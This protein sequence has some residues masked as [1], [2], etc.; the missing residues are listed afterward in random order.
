MEKKNRKIE[1][2]DKVRV[3]AENMNPGSKVYTVLAVPG[4]H[5]YDKHGFCD[6]ET[7]VIIGRRSMFN[8]GWGEW[9]YADAL[10]VVNDSKRNKT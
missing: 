4:M 7:G 1:V 10:E 6:A 5:R 3:V 8:N 9:I 2:G